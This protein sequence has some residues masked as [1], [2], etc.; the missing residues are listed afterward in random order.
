M[1]FRQKIFI[2]T[3]L[4]IIAIVGRLV[5][6]IWNMTPIAGVAI[7]AG[8]RLGLRWGIVIPIIGMFIGDAF[9]GFY[10]LPVML[11]VYFSFGLAGVVGYLVRKS[12]RMGVI[13][14]GSI[15]SAVLFFVVTNGAVWAFGAMYPHN[16]FGLTASY[17]AGLPFFQNQILG[18]LFFTAALFAV[19]ELGSALV[20]RMKNNELKFIPEKIV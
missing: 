5:P 4:I 1:V 17:V 11:S 7:L 14:G 10:S 16:F 8:A 13:L 2:A 20:R 12:G 6:H 19:W 3:G 9:I 15:L 18:D